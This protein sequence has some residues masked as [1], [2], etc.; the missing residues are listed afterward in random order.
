MFGLARSPAPSPVLDRTEP[1]NSRRGYLRQSYTRVA[2]HA[3]S[4]PGRPYDG[5]TLE[6][7]I[8]EIESLT[9][10]TLKRILAAAGYNFRLILKW[11]RLLFALIRIWTS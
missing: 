7:V 8:P 9:G 11:I 3:K 6:A 4:L 10:A 1:E 2:I 5:H